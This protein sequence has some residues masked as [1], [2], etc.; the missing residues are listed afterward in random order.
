[1]EDGI[2]VADFFDVAFLISDWMQ[3]DGLLNLL[4][5]R[6][7]VL[8]VN[9]VQKVLQG[10]SLLLSLDIGDELDDDRFFLDF[11]DA[12]LG[13]RQNYAKQQ[14]VGRLVIIWTRW[15]DINLDFSGRR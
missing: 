6:Q 3:H 2:S 1:V 11:N 15:W 5:P 10:I 13:L 14:V 12:G 7:L 8:G 4:A 9:L